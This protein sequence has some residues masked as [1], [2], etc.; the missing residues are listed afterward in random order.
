MRYLKGLVWCAIVCVLP[1]GVWAGSLTDP[2][3]PGSS[4]SAMYTLEDIYNR[5]DSGAAGAKRSGGFTEPSASPGS[6]GHTLDEVMEKAPTADNSN[7]AS[8]ADVVSGK[9]FW[10]LLTGGWGPLTG[11]MTNV[12][13]QNI[14]TPGTSAQTITQGYYDGTVFVEG[15]ENLSAG[16]IKCGVTIFGVTGTLGL[17][18]CVAKTGLT[19]VCSA[20]DDGAYQ[21]GCDP[22]VTP[23]NL[24]DYNRTSLP[25]SGGF[26]NN[27]DGTVTDNLTGLIW[28]K[29]ANCFGRRTWRNGLSDCNNLA[30]GTCGL[31]DGSSAGDWRLPNFN[32]LRS[33]FDPTLSAP[34][35]PAGHPFTNVQSRLYWSSSGFPDV[36]HGTWV[37]VVDLDRGFGFY[38]D[39][40]SPDPYVWPVRGGQ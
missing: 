17:P 6:S 29:N 8:A 5:L 38:D 25:C 9:T 28:L 37:W 16:N 12:G 18:V 19:T 11:T 36:M 20:G 33:L 22:A 10:G 13:A 21:K 15:D 39:G 35:L 31:N 24:S 27:G 34:Y 23:Y 14:T 32:E 26:T 2:G 1:A 30:S 4:S 40:E 3:T 7:G